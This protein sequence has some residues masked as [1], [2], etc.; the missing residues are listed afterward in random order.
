MGRQRAIFA[1]WMMELG[2]SR[3]AQPD[4][5]RRMGLHLRIYRWRIALCGFPAVIVGVALAVFLLTAPKPASLENAFLDVR[6]GMSQSEAIAILVV[7]DRHIDRVYIIG[8][9]KDG[10]AFLGGIHGFSDLP[11]AEDIEQAEMEMLDNEGQGFMVLLGRCGVVTG[12]RFT[13][14]APPETLAEWLSRFRLWLASS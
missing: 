7:A 12:K 5:L 3:L 4:K 11:R 13:P 8:E 14:S 1:A 9:A 6:V 2:Y 10:K